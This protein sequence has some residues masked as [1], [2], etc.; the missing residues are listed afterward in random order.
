[1]GALQ[2]VSE[3]LPRRCPPKIDAYSMSQALKNLE[4]A[5]AG[6]PILN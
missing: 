4:N 2:G 1:M 6:G 3:T 5:V